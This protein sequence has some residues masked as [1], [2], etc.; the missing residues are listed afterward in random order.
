MVAPGADRLAALE[1][2][3]AKYV[4]LCAMREERERLE[5]AGLMRFEGDALAARSARGRALAARFPGVL[6]E[7]DHCD[8]RT[9]RARLR[10]VEQEL[11]AARAGGPGSLERHWIAVM[12]DFHRLW[13]DELAARRSRGRAR[14]QGSAAEWIWAEI[15][16]RHGVTVAEA[17]AL[18]F[19]DAGP[20]R[21]NA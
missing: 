5:A 4:E 10:D 3:R 1:A 17:R 19:P 13:C 20:P 11:A 16:R 21:A 6:R 8:A 9:L 7:L 2:L 15:A 18:V 12:L 14:A